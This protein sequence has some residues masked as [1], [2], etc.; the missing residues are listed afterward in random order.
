MCRSISIS[1][2]PDHLSSFYDDP[3]FSECTHPRLGYTIPADIIALVGVSPTL[4][5]ALLKG[6][7]ILLILHPISAALSFLALFFSLFLALHSITIVALIVTLTSALLSSVV[8]AADIALVVLVRQNIGSLEDFKF[9]VYFGNAVWLAVAA[10]AC[11]WAATILL[12][13]RACYCCG[14]SR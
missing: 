3:N 11:T 14:I 12:S 6:L 1:I 7:L 10:L 4:V 13:A 5:N 2:S 9:S 8:V